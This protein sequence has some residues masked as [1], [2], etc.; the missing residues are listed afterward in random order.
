MSSQATTPKKPTLRQAIA[1]NRYMLKLAFHACPAAA[2]GRLA[3]FIIDRGIMRMFFGVYFLEQIIHYVETGAPFQQAALFLAI[4]ITLMALVQIWSSYYRRLLEPLGNQ[5]VY[6]KLHLHMFQKAA[7]V[8]LECFENPDFYNR[9]MKATSQIKGKAFGALNN[10]AFLTA[11]ILS[12]CYLTY[13][14]IATDPYVLL[15]AICPFLATYLLGGWTNRLSYQ[16]YEENMPH[17]RKK[18]YVK[19]TLYLQD[20]AKEIRLSNIYNI[21]MD[22]FHSA[23]SAII[24]NIRKYGLKTT[25]IYFLRDALNWTLVTG[26]T[27]CYAAL[28]LLYWKNIT[29]AD[30]V[31]LVSIII[32]YAASFVSIS[33]WLSKLQEDSQYIDDLKGFMHYE[34][35]ISQSQQGR[36]P[37]RHTS[38]LCM[39][40]VS[41]TYLG[42]DKPTLKDINLTIE[43]GQKVAL[44]G[45]NGA[46][47]TTLVKLLMRLY[48]AS[49]G[50]VLLGG[51]NI[52]EYNVRAYRDLFAAV[53]QDYKMIS[54]SVAEN[55]MMGHVDEDKR[56]Q[57]LDALKNSDVSDKIHTLKHGIDTTLGRE[58]DK[59]GAVLSG[60]EAQKIAIA[61]VFVKDCDFVILDE[62]SSA[63]DPIAEYNMYENMLKACEDKAMIFISH[64]LSSAVLADKI[65]LLENGTIIEEGNHAALMQ[66]NAKYAEMFRLQAESYR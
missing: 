10:A 52:K 8:E 47:K 38:A 30:F 13:K 34:P 14:S 48:D 43:P 23:I 12:V 41:Y 19:R 28:R 11:E 24:Q 21:L 1:N 46:G 20:Y 65:Y 3:Y 56:K 25:V 59:E 53:F 55:V 63:L 66:K 35:K 2:I 62:P 5:I 64:R 7:D 6:E 44:V 54:M 33:R 16:R 29:A 39:K 26:G 32:N 45:L 42:Q 57:I 36:E 50:E 27:I 60:G 37:A 51:H 40:N 58:F 9:Y 49:E 15:F 18:E 31:V 61:R 17:T 22:Q 4:A